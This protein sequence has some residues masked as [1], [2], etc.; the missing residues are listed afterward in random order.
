MRIAVGL[1]SVAI[2]VAL[3]V[4]AWLRDRAQQ[5]T[6]RPDA[7]GVSWRAVQRR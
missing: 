6:L 5:A 2:A 7:S 4:L 3:F 1:L